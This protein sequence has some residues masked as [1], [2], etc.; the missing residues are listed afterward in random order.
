MAVS[1]V[2]ED[3]GHCEEEEAS[4]SKVQPKLSQ[5]SYITIGVNRVATATEAV[6]FDATE[7]D[8]EVK[9]G[10]GITLE[11]QNILALGELVGRNAVDEARVEIYRH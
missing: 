10:T 5:S 9:S 2:R 3:Y 4:R 1:R 7:A 11:G 6:M 8:G